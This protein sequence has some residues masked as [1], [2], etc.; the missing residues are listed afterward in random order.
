MPSATGG[1]IYKNTINFV[2]LTYAFTPISRTPAHRLPSGLAG[3]KTNGFN[4]AREIHVRAVGVIG[5]KVSCEELL[6]LVVQH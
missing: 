4:K 1:S 6:R 3:G 2:H 5:I